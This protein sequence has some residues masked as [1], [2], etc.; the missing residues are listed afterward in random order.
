MDLTGFFLV[1][2]Q[3]AATLSAMSGL[4]LVVSQS[5]VL[6]IDWAVLISA[7]LMSSTGNSSSSISRKFGNRAPPGP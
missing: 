1:N 2:L 5:K 6:A 7:G 4:V 3:A